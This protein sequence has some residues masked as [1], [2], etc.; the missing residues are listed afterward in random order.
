MVRCIALSGFG[1][2]ADVKQPEKAGF[3]AHLICTFTEPT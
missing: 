2:E 3:D 1:E